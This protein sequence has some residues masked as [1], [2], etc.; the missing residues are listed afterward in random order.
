MLSVGLDA[1]QRLFVTCVLDSNG[2]V[3][4][5]EAVR[6][7]VENLERFLTELGEPFQICFE[8]S[9]G[10]GVLYD[11]LRRIARRVLVAHPGALRLIFRSK[12]K[13]DRVDA[14]KLATVLFLDQVPPVHVPSVDVRNWRALIEHRKRLVDKRTRAKNSIRAWLR[15]NGI[16]TP[17]RGQWL[18]S[19]SGRSWL[20]ALKVDCEFAAVRRDTQVEELA[21]FDRQI[22]RVT[23]I[24]D[25]I[26]AQHPAVVLLRSVPGVGPRTAEAIAAYVDDPKRFRKSKSVGSYFGLVPSQDQSGGRNHL[27]H[28]TRTG[29]G[30]ARKYLIEAAWQSIRYSDQA[31]SEYERLLRGD[32]QRRKIALVAL[33]HKIVRMMLA[34]LK[35]GEVCRWEKIAA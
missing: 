22:D 20:E 32:K 31:R 35:T 1:H 28:I 19:K 23:K 34:M 11:R 10:Y 15:S 13:S 3:V 27:G 16:E 25:G 9:C 17:K 5:T 26:A 6:G 2:K 29:P 7:N 33:A 30:T 18:W 14:K 12:Q 21:H 4:R 24:L 8:A